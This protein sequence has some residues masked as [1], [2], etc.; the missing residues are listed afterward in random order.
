MPTSASETDI[1][2]VIARYLEQNLNPPPDDP[3]TAET[4]LLDDLA[5]DSLQTFEMIALLEDHF[6]LT[7]SI[8]VMSDA[9]TVGDVARAVARVLAREAAQG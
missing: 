7:L 6:R 3:I 8:D 2:S 9:Q 5:L 1:L 4:R